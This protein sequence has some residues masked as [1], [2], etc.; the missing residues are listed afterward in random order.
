MTNKE[1]LE[2]ITKG[3]SQNLELVKKPPYTESDKKEL[4]KI[5]VAFAN[6]GDGF[7]FIGV[8]K[9]TRKITGLSPSYNVN[10][11]I[12]IDKK[13]CKPST[14]PEVSLEKIGEVQIGIVKVSK[15]MERPYCAEGDCYVRLDKQVYVASHGEIQNMYRKAVVFRR[16]GSDNWPVETAT[17]EDLDSGKVDK[18]LK[19][20]EALEEDKAVRNKE[21]VF[22]DKGILTQGANQLVPTAAAL[23]MFGRNPQYFISFSGVRLVRFQGKNIGSVI[24]DQKEARG[25]IPEMIDQAWEFLLKHMNVGAK[26]EG[27]KRD[28]YTEYP[29]VAVREAIANAIVHRDYGIEASQVRVFMFDDRI[30]IYT[31]G[32]LADGITV[33]NMEYTQYSRNKLITEMLMH[34][35][36]YI[37]KLGTGIKRI[38]FVLK[39]NRLR[40]PVLIDSGIDFILTIFGPVSGSRHPERKDL[41]DRIH[42]IIGPTKSPQEIAA[43]AGKN[44]DH[45]SMEEKLNAD[46]L[47]KLLIDKAKKINFRSF[48]IAVIAGSLL[49]VVIVAI[50]LK[51][52]S[53]DPVTL[54]QR[55]AV[56][57]S[58]G[59]YREAM[60][61]YLR[62]LLEF[63]SNQK[64]DSAQYYMAG[65]RDILGEDVGALNAYADL[66]KKYPK[67]RWVPYAY[68]WRGT[69][70]LDMGEL[71]KAIAEYKKLTDG[72]PD[73]PIALSAMR[74]IAF[75]LYEKDKFQEAIDMYERILDLAENSSDGQEYYQIGLCYLNLGYSDKAK[76]MFM[77]VISDGGSSPELVKD[78]NER[79]SKL[80]K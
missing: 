67:S 16:A 14:N 68:Y 10:D 73:H 32:G 56:L 47:L 39:Q 25:V 31:P 11:V 27:L 63:P 12:E 64:S 75:C 20:I 50:L 72:Y 71:D 46:K 62:F 59:E 48:K 54:Y 19:S 40:D 1:I 76:E 30:E 35:G 49:L 80:G 13:Y 36:R 37:E 23:L 29:E 8:D 44:S 52:S 4:A 3:N 24:V 53:R 21:K 74:N 51:A 2:F 79:I 15:G 78:A 34:T 69:I 18:Y 57:H 6:S 28:D 60:D 45:L 17:R 41:D 70:Y 5:M 43:L 77:K 58:R 61:A 65:C 22:T 55:A 38:K 42:K 9:S 66:L 26:I 7:I 33:A